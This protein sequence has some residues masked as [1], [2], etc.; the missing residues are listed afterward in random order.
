MLQDSVIGPEMSVSKHES[1]CNIQEEDRPL[2][3]FF[4]GIPCFTV[5]WPVL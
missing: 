5:W 1:M 2:N 4:L 3:N